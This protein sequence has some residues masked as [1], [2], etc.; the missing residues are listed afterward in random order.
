MSQVPGQSVGEG[1][2]DVELLLSSQL[3]V[4]RLVDGEEGKIDGVEKIAS[5]QV[6]V[7]QWKEEW[8]QTTG[9]TEGMKVR[10][11]R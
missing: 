1:G 3:T 9:E 2:C 6:T 8:W 5:L 7:M 4:I 10:M 11:R